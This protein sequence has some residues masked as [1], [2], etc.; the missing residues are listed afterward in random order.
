MVYQDF[1]IDDYSWNVQ[2]C[3][4]VEGNDF[5][6]VI[7]LLRHFY[8]SNKINKVCIENISKNIPNT[9]F[10]CT[11]RMTRKTLIVINK[12]TSDEELINT[13]CHELRHLTSH[14]ATVY[15]IDEKGEEVCYLTGDIA[16]IMYRTFK[17]L[18]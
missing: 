1:Y 7:D 16:K 10:T 14:I 2:V 18:L 13:I 4:D 9:G 6:D 12:C 17:R 3:Y 11:N 5:Y 8:F 15:N